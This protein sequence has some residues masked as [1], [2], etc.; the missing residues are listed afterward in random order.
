MA[1]YRQGRIN[2]QLTKELA[3]ILRTVKDPRVNNALVSITGAECAADLKTAK[4]YYSAIGT[5][6]DLDEIKKGLVSAAG[7]I[8]RQVAQRLNLRNT[9]ELRFILDES[10][11][12]GAHMSELLRAIADKTP[13]SDANEIEKD[14][15]KADSTYE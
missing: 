13:E 6:V 9:P 5:N 4:I 1:G 14:E 7:Y 15:V 11:Q 3:E 2:E 12:K 8:R 10:M